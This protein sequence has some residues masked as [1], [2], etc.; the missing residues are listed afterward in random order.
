MPTCLHAYGLKFV[1]DYGQI[2]VIPKDDMGSVCISFPGRVIS[3]ITPW[4]DGSTHCVGIGS[5]V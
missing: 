1:A 5:Q 3:K 2:R 4:H